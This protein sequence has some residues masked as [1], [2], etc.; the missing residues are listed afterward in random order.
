[1]AGKSTY[2]RQVALAVILAQAGAF[3][4][5]SRAHIGI[6]DRVFTRIGA[7]DE[8][9]R[10]MSTFMVEMAE[11]AAILNNA[12][13]RSLV[14]LDEVGRGTS[15]FDGLALAWSITEFI[16]DRL[17]CRCLFATH[18]HELTELAAERPRIGNRTVSVA[19]QDE[20]V[21]FLHRIIPGAATKSYGIHVARLA[22]VPEVV[23]GRAR[24]EVQA[25]LDELNIDLTHREA[26]G[27]HGHD[28]PVQLTLFGEISHP[29][30]EQLKALDVDALS[31]RQAMDLL[32]K[33]KAGGN[34]MRR[35][36]VL[37]FLFV[38]GILAQ[39]TQPVLP[40]PPPVVV[41]QGWY[42]TGPVGWTMDGDNTAFL[43]SMRSPVLASNP[44]P[45]GSDN[46][47]RAW[48]EEQNR[49]GSATLSYRRLHDGLN[50]TELFDQWIKLLKEL[51]AE[52]DILADDR[53]PSAMTQIVLISYKVGTETWRQR[54]VNRMVQEPRPGTDFAGIW[55]SFRCLGYLA[56]DLQRHRNNPQQA[57][58]VAAN[59]MLLIIWSVSILLLWILYGIAIKKSGPSGLIPR[60]G[61]L[62]AIG[63]SLVL[64]IVIFHLLGMAPT[65][66]YNA[67]SDSAMRL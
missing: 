33:L 41:V 55:Q 31:P 20:E 18:Y 37:W 9:A 62:T 51:A 2:I 61:L 52:V 26:P 10:N 16:D 28:N 21:V 14:I 4:P 23:V 57:G 59:V 22:G 13:R 8:L 50:T 15:T 35:C 25:T 17:R 48:V 1:M 34:Q 63:K 54:I 66:Q 60:F 12:S 7:G 56:N 67:G 42:I 44:G 65:V 11:T 36:G 49:M 58:K 53:D 45:E 30:L 32:Y 43:G 46:D 3:V 5:A 40:V 47:I 6:V 27:A 24:E 19:E 39:E 64:I 38:C 29:A